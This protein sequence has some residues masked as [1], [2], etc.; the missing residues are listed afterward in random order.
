[1]NTNVILNENVDGLG[2]IGDVVAV[3][4]GYARNYLVPQ[5]LASVADARN[6]KELEHQKR[7]LSRK[8]EKV[9]KDAEGVKAR[10]ERV[11]CEFSQRASEEGKLFGSVTSMDLEAKLQA[12]GIEIDRKKIQLSEPIKSLGEHV[13]PVKLDAGVVAELKVV[14]TAEAEV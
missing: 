6:V 7:Q 1:M 14:V 3:K 10:I 12:A 5:G 2:T 11:T 13:V 8:L 9:T 4:A